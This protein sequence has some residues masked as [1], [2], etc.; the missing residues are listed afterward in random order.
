MRFK[1]LN[2]GEN[3]EDA[4]VLTELNSLTSKN[5]QNVACGSATSFAVSSEGLWLIFIVVQYCTNTLQE[6]ST[7]GEWVLTDN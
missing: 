5:I 2:L 3:C 6:F 7:A 4:N 1:D